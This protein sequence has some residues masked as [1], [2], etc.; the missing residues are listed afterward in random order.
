MPITQITILEANT[1][2][3]EGIE[4]LSEAAHPTMVAVKL[5]RT[6]HV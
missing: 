1:E 4:V 2:T 6:G 5:D 3:A